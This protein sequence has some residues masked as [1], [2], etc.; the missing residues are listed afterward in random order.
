MQ[1]VKKSC[2]LRLAVT[3]FL[4]LSERIGLRKD[5]AVADCNARTKAD[6]G[7]GFPMLVCIRMLLPVL[8]AEQCA[9]IRKQGSRIVIGQ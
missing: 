6:A 7:A 5:Y 9:L 2:L 4:D 8:R 3:V 1:M